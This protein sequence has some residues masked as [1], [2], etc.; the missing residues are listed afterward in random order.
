MIQKCKFDKKRDIQRVD[1]TLGVNLKECIRNGVVRDT[2]GESFYNRQ[3]DVDEV[4]RR[5]RDVFD[6]VEAEGALENARKKAS[7]N[8]E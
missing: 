1:S 4:G 6:V 5:V 2:S 7:E 8:A 3:E